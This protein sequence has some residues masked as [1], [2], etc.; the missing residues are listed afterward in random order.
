MNQSDEY[1]ERSKRTKRVLLNANSHFCPVLYFFLNRQ[2]VI[3]PLTQEE[4]QDFCT[5][6]STNQNPNDHIWTYVV[7]HGDLRLMNLFSQIGCNRLHISRAFLRQCVQTGNP[8]ALEWMM[9]QMDSI[10]FSNMQQW[11]KRTFHDAIC[12]GTIKQ[13]LP[14]FEKWLGLDIYFQFVQACIK[15]EGL[16][17]IRS[18]KFLSHSIE[19]HQQIQF[20]DRC[21]SHLNLNKTLHLID[22]C[23][24]IYCAIG[25]V[26]QIKNLITYLKCLNVTRW[27]PLLDVV[28]HWMNTA[29]LFNQRELFIL[30]REEFSHMRDALTPGNCNETLTDAFLYMSVSDLE[31]WMREWNWNGSNT[32]R[33]M[34]VTANLESQQ[35]D[36]VKR[37]YLTIR[38]HE[39]PRI[40]L[41]MRNWSIDERLECYQMMISLNDETMTTDE[42]SQMFLKLF[43]TNWPEII[44]RCSVDH[45]NLSHHLEIPLLWINNRK[46][47]RRALITGMK[48]YVNFECVKL[49]VLPFISLC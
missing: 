7:A 34:I 17:I 10:N 15:E 4:E 29:M 26:N 25:Y 48:K 39:R 49:Y 11:T 30:I 1:V 24:H 22:A 33:H 23:V 40:R 42:K 3:A 16:D 14:V 44:D 35:Y 18:S 32:E 20:V 2:D 27:K 31:F 36:L 6:I 5:L 9:D 8:V 12:F 43:P 41:M 37:L 19:I 46:W 21:I 28:R 38:P 45:L 13:L 47:R